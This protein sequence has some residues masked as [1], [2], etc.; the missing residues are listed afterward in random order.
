MTIERA[1]VVR[2]LLAVVAAGGAA[3]VLFFFAPE[4]HGFYPRC[5]FHALTGLQCPGCGGLRAAHRLLHGDLAG[6]FHFNPLM[7]MLAPLVVV[8][9]A[10]YG[11]QWTRS[12]RIWNSF[13][14][15]IWGWTL[16]AISVAFGIIRN[17]P[18]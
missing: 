12:A 15:P 16:L 4:Q 2:I 11:I 18:R 3:S 9:L 6:A 7:V 17:L 1:K 5:L 8:W 10:A 13:S 14:R